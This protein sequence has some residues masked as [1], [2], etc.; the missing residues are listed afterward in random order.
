MGAIKNLPFDTLCDMSNTPPATLRPTPT[1]T[2]TDAPSE[3]RV[4]SST[5]TVESFSVDLRRLHG[6]NTAP[7]SSIPDIRG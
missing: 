6:N 7:E 1:C 5:C 2:Q 3:A 4:W